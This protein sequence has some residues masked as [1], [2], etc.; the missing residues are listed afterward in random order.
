MKAKFGIIFM[1]LMLMPGL[2][3]S[4]YRRQEKPTPISQELVR[5]QSNPFMGLSLL[6]PSKL[7]MSHSF[8]MSFFSM[9][10]KGVSQGLYLN[11]LTYQIANP[12]LFRLQWGIQSYPYNTLSK[13]HPAFQSGLFLSGAELLYKPSDKFEMK[14]QINQTPYY[15]RYGSGWY[16]N[17]Y[18]S[19]WDLVE[20][21]NDNN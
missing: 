1:M 5:P 20:P 12:L 21:S 9:D 11:T 6:D 3:F 19:N 15:N 17:P 7:H 2:I 13:N 14:F 8:S 4:Q 16:R 10:G 18:R